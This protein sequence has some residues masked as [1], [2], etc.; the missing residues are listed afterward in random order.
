MPFLPQHYLFLDKDWHKIC[1]L[2]YLVARLMQICVEAVK[3]TLDLF[4]KSKRVKN[5]LKT[6]STSQKLFVRL[7]K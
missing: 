5:K 6:I 7:V 4:A 2:A 1:W 3:N